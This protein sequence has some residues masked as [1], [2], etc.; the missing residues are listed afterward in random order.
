VRIHTLVF[1]LACVAACAGPERRARPP[2]PGRP[3][4]TVMTYNVNF[5][6]AGDPATIEVIRRGGADVVF[7]QETTEAW[8]ASLRGELAAAYPHMQFRHCCGAGGLAVLSRHPFTELD[9]WEP[10]PGGWFPAWRL[11]VDSPLGAIEVLNVHLKPPLDERGSVV[12]G[13]HASKRIRVDEISSYVEGLGGD[14]PL[15]IVGDFNEGRDGDALAYLRRRGL[16]SALPE[17]QPDADTWRWTTTSGSTVHAQL[18]H[19]V[20]DHSLVPIDA[21]VIEGG[22]SDHLAVLVTVESIY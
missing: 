1:A 7:L 17:L 21:T 9:Y 22:R 11:E 6:I 5:G 4:L 19:V 18:D 15:L 10:P 8:E 3:H 16:R 12:R 2:T 14:L 20:V 13:Y